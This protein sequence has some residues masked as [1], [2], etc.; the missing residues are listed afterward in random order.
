MPNDITMADAALEL[1][2]RGYRMSMKSRLS[3]GRSEFSVS[4]FSQGMLVATSWQPSL[5][6]ALADALGKAP[7]S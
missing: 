2:R 4:L 1:S 3:C 5:V 6:E 7:Q